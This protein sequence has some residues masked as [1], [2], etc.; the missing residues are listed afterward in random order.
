MK[1]LIVSISNL[2]IH[3]IKTIKR[4]DYLYLASIGTAVLFAANQKRKLDFSTLLASG[5]LG[6][7]SMSLLIPYGIYT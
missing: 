4:L 3:G 5:G 2:A 6:L 7:G 1:S